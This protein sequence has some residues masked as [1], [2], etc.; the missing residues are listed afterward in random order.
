MTR[1]HAK[2]NMMVFGGNLSF[3]HR[4]QEWSIFRSRFI[5]YCTANDIGDDTDKSG[6][7]RRALLLTALVEDTYRVAR[8]LVFPEDLD[9]VEFQTLLEKLNVHFQSKKSTFAERYSFYKAEQRPGE[10]LAEWASRVR[11]LAQYCGFKKEL[12]TALRDK[13]VLGLENTKEKEKLF[14]ESIETLTFN[15]ALEMAQ[16]VRCARAAL[17]TARAGNAAAGA[18]GA[19]TSAATQAQPVFAMQRPSTSSSSSDSSRLLKCCEVC[20]YKNHQKEK[21]RFIDYVC[22][23]CNKK[24]HLKRMCKAKISDSNFLGTDD[25][26]AEGIYN[27]FNLKNSVKDE[28]IS[29]R[30]KLANQEILC[31][32][33][34]G[35]AVSVLPAVIYQQLF[36]RYNLQPC[37]EVFN[38]YTGVKISPMGCLS[39][40]V[41]FEGK[42]KQVIFFVIKTNEKRLPLLGRDFMR[43]FNLHLC[44]L[45]CNNLS[46]NENAGD[47]LREKYAKLF[48]DELGKFNKYKV[49]LKIK[50]DAHLKFFKSRP[51]PLAL[52]PKIEQELDRLL[53]AGILEKVD[54]SDVA[55]P[56][57]PVLRPDGNVRICGDFSVTLNKV[58]YLDNYTLPRIEDLFAKLHGGV[59]FSKLDLKLAYLQLELDDSKKWCC[60]NTHRGLYRYTRLVLGLANAPFI[61]QRTMEQLLGDIDGVCIYLDDILITAPN[62][63]LHLE[64]LEL[65][66]KRLQ[67]AGLRVKRDKCELFKSSVEYLGY[68][69]DKDGLHKSSGK[70]DAIVNCT[71]PKNVSELKSF[72]GMVNYYRCFV[73]NTSSVLSALNNLLKKGI[74]WDWG[75]A[76][77][78]AF[79]RI[80]KELASDRV[81]AHYHPE[82]PTVVTCDAGPEGLGAVLAQQQPDGSERVLAY[83]SRS[84]SKAE[85]NYAQIQKEATSIVFAVKKFNHYLYGRTV[86]F[87]LRTDHKPLLSI[88]GKEKG[89]PILAANRLQRYAL[90]LSAYNFKIEYVKSDD[91]VADF[92]SRSVISQPNAI[93]DIEYSRYIN[94]IGESVLLPITMEDIRTETTQDTVLQRVIGFIRNGWPS[95]VMNPE[96][97]PFFLCRLD[98]AVE[99]GCILRGHKIVI[100]SCFR[101]RLLCELHNSHFGVVKTKSEARMRMWWPNID[102]H[103]EEKIGSCSV[104]NSLRSNPP[105][106]PLVSWPYP[107]SAWERVH[108]D[109]FMLGGK[110]F[111]IA[112]DAHS[113]WVE[114]F[115]M[116]KTDSETIISKLCEM[117]SRFGL[118]RTLVTDNASNFCSN[119]FET[120]C[121]L[122]GI[123]H[124]TGAPYHAMSNGQAENSVK[125]VKNGLKAILNNNVNQ[126]V[127]LKVLNKFLFDYRNSIHLTTGFSP[128]QLMFG[129]PLRCRF[130]LLNPSQAFSSSSSSA[131]KDNVIKAQNNQCKQFGG[132]R[133]VSFSV[134][135]K[136][137]LKHYFSNGTKHIW[138]QGLVNKSLGSRM[139]L[140]Y[141]PNENS[142]VKKHI[143]Q[144]LVYKGNS[145]F[146]QDDDVSVF[147]DCVTEIPG[148]PNKP[149]A[150]LAS[151]PVPSSQEQ[152]PVSPTSPARDDREEDVGASSDDEFLDAGSP[153]VQSDD[154]SNHSNEDDNAHPKPQVVRRYPIRKTRKQLHYNF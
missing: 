112:V 121:R 136:V 94:F 127:W 81:L 66:M 115:A 83:A 99:S 78:D 36:G 79:E 126:K 20:G 125:T 65:V 22:Q 146:D 46:V 51:V 3:D 16:S 71:P 35:S 74:K 82:Y 122:N 77:S 57:V 58:L 14:A 27:L 111:L 13:F 109:M 44:S 88:F 48:S 84:L 87:V 10:D 61:F 101:E 59:E 143:D 92:L 96:L 17:Q 131:A 25:D 75:Q 154:H 102:K 5:Q 95:K 147:G 53:E 89:V 43:S 73:P 23:K 42:S 55:T 15:K 31:E 70:I 8:D 21:C 140:V 76:Q 52:K 149:Q 151:D 117:F 142:Y 145:S 49:S 7:R 98:L 85:I 90:F 62:R 107:K 132:K 124:L 64:R 56:I 119:E 1:E 104:C 9:S 108:L 114:C 72:L 12:E 18:A 150:S 100:P 103:I 29:R 39:L 2:S 68:V 41:T 6:M 123:Q 91:N 129:R 45:N 34:C 130:D 24:G 54:H 26:D 38:F 86:P 33:D 69:I 28:P 40:P 47:F 113:K 32:I 97:R 133:N 134:G 152:V 106:V 139:F 144:L 63:A 118:V 60:I 141:I 135:D 105:K 19:G 120:F 30:V 128:A 148:Q 37:N 50:P 116:Q 138:K 11:N 80:K 67:D 137:L 4:T 93:E 110:Q 153:T